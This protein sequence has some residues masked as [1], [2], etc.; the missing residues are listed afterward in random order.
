MPGSTGLVLESHLAKYCRCRVLPLIK[1]EGGGGRG[2]ARGVEGGGRRFQ[3]EVVANELT[4]TYRVWLVPLRGSFGE[5][6]PQ[7]KDCFLPFLAGQRLEREAPMD[8]PG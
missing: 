7:A 1:R 2:N 4:R 5:P 8:L 6:V 3:S